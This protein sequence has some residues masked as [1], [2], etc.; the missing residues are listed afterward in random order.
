MLKNILQE[1]LIKFGKSY[2]LDEKI[3]NKLILSFLFSRLFMMLRGIFKT[4]R[5]VFV[6]SKT[7]ILNSKNF[8]FGHSCT[9]EKN[10]FIDCYASKEITFGNV[11]KIGAFSTIS[12]T[13]HLSKYGIGLEIGN[14]SAVGE[15]SYFGCSGGIKIGNDVIMGQY[16]SFHSENHIFSNTNQLIRE[17][18]VTSIGIELGNNIWVGSKATFLDGCKIGDNSVVAAGSVVK[19]VFPPNV[20]IGGVPAKIIKQINA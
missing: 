12:T 17:Q 7:Q 9:I 2:S 5:K 3:S 15:Y 10:V 8:K 11:V 6:G 14:N 18:G 16:I 4:K 20:V 19:D 13:S 1:L